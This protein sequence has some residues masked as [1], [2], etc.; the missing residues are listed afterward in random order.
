MQA[1]ILAAGF[2]TRLLPHTRLRPK[3]LFPILNQPLLL[4]TINRL[5]RHGFHR[6]IVNCHHL[7]EQIVEQISGIEGVIVQ[8]EDIILGTGGGLRRALPQMLDEPLLVTNGDIYH[9]VNY[10]KLYAAHLENHCPATLAMHDYPRFNTVRVSE[11]HI[12]DFRGEAGEHDKLAFTGLYVLDPE[13]LATITDGVPSCIVAHYRNLLLHGGS[14]AVF[15]ADNCFWTDMGTPQDY[16]AL[17]EGLLTGAIPRWEELMYDGSDA[18]WVDS[19]AQLSGDTQLSGWCSLGRVKGRDV[20]LSRVVIWD[21]VELP[22]G[23]RCEHALISTSPGSEKE[24][25]EADA[26]VNK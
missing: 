12:V 20:R 9:T 10:Q 3:P 13:I 19:N 22:E 14:L 8:Q 16:L 26:V 2:G 7:Q 21:G 18:L 4:L 11:G 17:H 25:S 5:K 24:N 6:I 1:M 15:R 23:Y